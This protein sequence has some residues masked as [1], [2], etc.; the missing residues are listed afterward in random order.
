MT[1]DIKI[2]ILG[3]LLYTNSIIL[4]VIVT[5]ASV[6]TLSIIFLVHV[7]KPKREMKMTLA[8]INHQ[9][10]LWRTL[11]H[12]SHQMLMS[13]KVVGLQWRGCQHY[14][15]LSLNWWLTTG[16]HGASQVIAFTDWSV[17]VYWLVIQSS[18]ALW[19]MYKP[20][21]HWPGWPEVLH[22]SNGDG[23]QYYTKLCESK[24]AWCLPFI[25]L[26]HASKHF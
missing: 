20:E 3:S 19:W 4:C 15:Q 7:L 12:C 10:S 9:C 8:S 25:K 26:S 22:T 5:I 11:L 18:L 21:E 14:K 24:D 17:I 2:Y 16:I 6:L 1:Y 13:V 23:Y